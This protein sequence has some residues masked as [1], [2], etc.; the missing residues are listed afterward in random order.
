MKF[1]NVAFLTLAALIAQDSMSEASSVAEARVSTPSG[2]IPE[3]NPQIDRIET[4]TSLLEPSVSTPEMLMVQEFSPSI[5]ASKTGELIVASAVQPLS[6]S[7][8]FSP[9]SQQKF[10]QV[11][12]RTW[13]ALLVETFSNR[14]R[15]S[16]NVNLATA[17]TILAQDINPNEETDSEFN[18]TITLLNSLLIVAILSPVITMG[19]FWLLR[20][21]VIREFVAEANRSLNRVDGL[22]EQINYSSEQSKQ[23]AQEL[24]LQIKAT[25]D[26]ID[27]LKQEASASRASI[28]QLKE[29]QLNLIENLQKLQSD[30]KT[31][32]KSNVIQF[33]SARNRY[34]YSNNHQ[35]QSPTSAELEEIFQFDSSPDFI[36][37]DYLKQGEALA[38]ENRYGE[39]L[40]C[41]EKAVKLNS[42]L[43]E[44]WYNQG[45]ILVRLSRYT[46]ALKAYEQVVKIHPDKYE[47]WY[48][49][50]NVLVKLKRYS[51][52][53]E[54]Y[55]RALAIQPNDDEAWHN[56]GVLL[57]K[58]KRYNE[59]LFS[60]DKAL[61]IQ[62]NKYETWHNRGNVLGK[63]KRYEEAINSYDRAITID[64]GKREVW[65]N[66]AVALCKLKRYD[67]A[68]ASFEQAIGLDP[69]SPELW[70][71]RG[72]LLQQLGE[73][74]EAIASFETAISHQ[75]NCYEAWLG[76]GTVLVQL[77]QYSEALSTY[78]QAIEI[79]PEASEAWRHQGLLLEKLERYP[80]AIAAYD[81][82]I[83][84]QPNDAEAWRFRGAL[85]SK[86]KNYQEAISSLGKAISIQKELRTV[87]IAATTDPTSA[88]NN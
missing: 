79:K 87:K 62:E 14:S 51:E 43:E 40:N 58:F 3:T 2:I 18:H 47:A 20:R 7:A 45:N 32:E 24:E 27:F 70:N 28:D 21:L 36:A 42:N 19:F 56:R 80:D 66:R 15:L 50:G 9:S 11:L 71:M 82:A 26:S 31:Q 8:Q 68:L 52:A 22:E 25:Q 30:F 64:A 33:T 83:K 74:S 54:S 76:K 78:E 85:L 13:L 6:G 88:S 39:A 41:F 67:Q 48:N 23:L 49:R 4:N 34:N 72:S 86:L 57:R 65:L 59:A 44:A 17:N 55:D 84:L 35:L 61:A 53:L 60:Y 29:L 12:S 5:S 63:L 69:T 77:K 1:S 37:D 16:S 38:N 10:S 75:P 46:E 81:E 73:Y